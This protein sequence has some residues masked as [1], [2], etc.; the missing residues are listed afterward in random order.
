MSSKNIMDII[1]K[2]KHCIV[3]LIE[4]RKQTCLYS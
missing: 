3:D 2:L 4:D 1:Q